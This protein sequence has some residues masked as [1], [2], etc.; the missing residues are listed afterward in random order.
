MEK[1][2]LTA[3]SGFLGAGKT[4]LIDKILTEPFGDMRSELVFIGQNLDKDAITEAFDECHLIMDEVLR[5][6]DYW[7][8]LLDP[9]SEWK[10]H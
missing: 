8:T 4:T 5:G 3:L 2:L 7:K 10:S 9:F 1:L 6:K